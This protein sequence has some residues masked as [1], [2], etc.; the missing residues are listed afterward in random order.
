MNLPIN[1]K[2][3]QSIRELINIDIWKFLYVGLKKKIIDIDFIVCFAEQFLEAGYTSNLAVTIA[4]L[5]KKEHVK[6][7]KLLENNYSTSDTD[8]DPLYNEAWFYICSLQNMYNQKL[9]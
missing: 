9:L 1:K 4:G 6:V 7:L 3:M 2:I 5:L 8:I